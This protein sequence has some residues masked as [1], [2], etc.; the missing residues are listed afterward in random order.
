MSDTTATD[1]GQAKREYQRRWYEA[2]RERI[3]E[4]NAAS[5]DRRRKYMQTW[6]E[7]SRDRRREYKTANRDRDN[8]ARRQRRA[9][10]REQ[11][12]RY[13]AAVR[14][15]ARTAVFDHYGWACA[16]P[17]CGSTT[18]LCIDHIGGNGK[19]HRAELGIKGGSIPMYRWLIR[20][21]FP[22]G[23]QTLCHSC[24]TS[25]GSGSACRLKHPA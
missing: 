22:E 16:C 20:N 23:Y 21:G 1:R 25:K 12:L 2:N 9:A 13:E 6:R 3:R 19:Q 5:R 17:G 11:A 8:E 24:N 7:T 18:R 14:E 15:R 4:R 10:N